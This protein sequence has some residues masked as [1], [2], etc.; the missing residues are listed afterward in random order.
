V[1]DTL[2]PA[3]SLKFGESYSF[4]RDSK[5]DPTYPLD[6]GS[7]TVLSY[8]SDVAPDDEAPE[9]LY[10]HLK[11]HYSWSA[12][13]VRICHDGGTVDEGEDDFA[14]ISA[15]PWLLE[16]SDETVVSPF[17]DNLPGFPHPL[18]PTE[19]EDLPAGACRT[20]N[21]VFAVPQGKAVSRALYVREGRLPVVWTSAGA[22]GK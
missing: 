9:V 3:A 10:D 19:E 8:E 2:R 4:E 21:I 11:G 5:I 1:A 20:G 15:W 6:R 17:D 22:G 14:T 7:M 16:L 18:Y 12:L 13:K